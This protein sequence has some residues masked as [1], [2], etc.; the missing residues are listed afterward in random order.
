M[1][2]HQIVLGIGYLAIITLLHFL[3]PPVHFLSIQSKSLSAFFKNNGFRIVMSSLFATT[4]VVITNKY[5]ALGMSDSTSIVAGSLF[6]LYFAY[7]FFKSDDFKRC[8][9]Q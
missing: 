9:K 6:G 8:T 1:I 7:A 2:M 3:L 4:T 5:P